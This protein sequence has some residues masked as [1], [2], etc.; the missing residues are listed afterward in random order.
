[1]YVV[2]CDFKNGLHREYGYADVGNA[3]QQYRLLIEARSKQTSVEI[4]DEGG[5]QAMPDCRDLMVVE[6]VDVQKE[7]LAA[8]VLVKEVQDLQRKAGLIQEQP[9]PAYR[10]P[11]RDEAPEYRGAIGGATRFAS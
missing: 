10:E 4:F 1:M 6:L 2:R 7:T 5:R 11:A 8:I 3:M 9:Q